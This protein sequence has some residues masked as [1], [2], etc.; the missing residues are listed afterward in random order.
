MDFSLAT[1]ATIQAP[2]LFGRIPLNRL[3][4]VDGIGYTERTARCRRGTS[5]VSSWGF[6][7]PSRLQLYFI[8]NT[9]VERNFPYPS[10]DTFQ[11]KLN[12]NLNPR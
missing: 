4:V 5:F 1:G 9:G 6:T 7:A 3:F 8:G 2:S 11:K 12:R 10:F